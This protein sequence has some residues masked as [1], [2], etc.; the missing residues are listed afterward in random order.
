MLKG[1]LTTIRALEFEDLEHVWRWQNDIRVMEQLWIEPVSRRRLELD[2]QDQLRSETSQRFIIGEL[3]SGRP[4]GLIWYYSL[5]PHSSCEDRHLYR[6]SRSTWPRL[7]LG[8]PAGLPRLP[9]PRERGA[10]GRAECE[11]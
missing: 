2:Y 7:R 10:P 4:I 1:E 3:E 8:R 11:R 9:L 6:R 5:H